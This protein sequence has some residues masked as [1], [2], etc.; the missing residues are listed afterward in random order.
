MGDGNFHLVL[1][2]KPRRPGRY[3]TRAARLNE[4]LVRRA[5]QMGGHLHGRAWNRS[6]QAGI[7]GGGGRGAGGV[8]LMRQI[9]RTFDPKG[10]LNPGKIFAADG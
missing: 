4:R 8:A 3:Q 6:R 10:I 9:K 7:P 2:R 1:L 5:L